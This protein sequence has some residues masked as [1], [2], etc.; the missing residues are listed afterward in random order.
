MNTKMNFRRSIRFF[1]LAIVGFA[2]L[3]GLM[4]V[5]LMPAAAHSTVL[6]AFVDPIASLP[7]Y[8]NPML[9][10]NPWIL[11]LPPAE[12]F[13]AAKLTR[14]EE[15]F[16]AFSLPQVSTPPECSYLASAKQIDAFSTQMGF[17]RRLV[18][19]DLQAECSPYGNK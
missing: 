10:S 6:E 2:L 3:L 8:S 7:S 19:K 18:F 13:L 11:A 14:M 15:L 16:S 9:I 12:R 17:N 5:F 4:S 1:G